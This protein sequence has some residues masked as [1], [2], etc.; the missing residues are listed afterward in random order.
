MVSEAEEDNGKISRADIRER[1]HL[2][3]NATVSCG[4]VLRAFLQVY[5]PRMFQKITPALR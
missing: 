4:M 2:P 3:N 1:L 5:T